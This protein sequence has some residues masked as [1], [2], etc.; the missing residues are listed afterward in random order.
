MGVGVAVAP[1]ASAELHIPPTISD[2]T[3]SAQIVVLKLLVFILIA[4]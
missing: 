1:S 3:A 4:S 2:A